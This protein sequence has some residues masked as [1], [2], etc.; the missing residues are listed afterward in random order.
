MVVPLAMLVSGVVPRPQPRAM[1]A[2]GEAV[3]HAHRYQRLCTVAGADWDKSLEATN[4]IS[5][6]I[7]KVVKLAQISKN[8]SF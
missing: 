3:L 4:E 1:L 6:G 8:T 7:L 5:F 2:L